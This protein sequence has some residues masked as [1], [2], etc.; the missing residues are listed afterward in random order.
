M[1]KLTN[2]HKKP[3]ENHQHYPKNL[4]YSL[5]HEWTK[6]GKAANIISTQSLQSFNH[7]NIL[8]ETMN[9]IQWN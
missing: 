3:H 2:Y 6:I 4:L 7:L 8:K 5:Y 1:I 9:L